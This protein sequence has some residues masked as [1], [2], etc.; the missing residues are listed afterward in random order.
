VTPFEVWTQNNVFEDPIEQVARY[1]DHVRI[2]HMEA[3][4]YN[5]EAEDRIGGDLV[6]YLSG[7]G[8]LTEEN[9]DEVASQIQNLDRISDYER[10][11]RIKA[12]HELGWLNKN[13]KSPLTRKDVGKIDDFLDLSARIQAGT[14]E[15]DET[16][17][18]PTEV[19]VKTGLVR[20]VLQRAETDQRTKLFNRGEINAAVVY[21][22]GKPRLLGGRIPEG[23]TI[24]D[25]IK[26]SS[27]YGVRPQHFFN[28]KFNNRIPEYSE[29][30]YTN[31]NT[32]LKYWEIQQRYIAE[33]EAIE[34]IKQDR[35]IGPMHQVSEN[36]HLSIMLDAL[37]ESKARS[38]YGFWDNVGTA[39]ADV[40]ES[41]GQLLAKIFG[42]QDEA[43][44]A[45]EEAEFLQETYAD[46]FS[47]TRDSLIADL[48]A[49]LD[50]S[51]DVLEDVADQLTLD[52]GKAK[53]GTGELHD[54]K[55]EGW[56]VYHENEDDQ[57]LNV[58][59]GT[60]KLPTV[61][62]ELKARPDLHANALD[63]A[64]VDSKTQEALEQLRQIEVEASFD[65]YNDIISKD[66]DLGDK[67]SQ[68][69]VTG[70][71][72]GISN[73]EILEQFTTDE[74]NWNK[75]S[76]SME[77]LGRSIWDE[78]V[79]GIV[80]GIAAMSGAEWGQQGLLK[81]ASEKAHQ[82]E[83]GRLFGDKFGL[84]QDALEMIAPVML[85]MGVTGL[86]AA[87]AAPTFG[88]TGAAAV[89]YV[90]AKTSATVA[91]RQII[92]AAFRGSLRVTGKESF[93]K[94]AK[95][96]FKKEIVGDLDQANAVIR[97][98]NSGL[99]KKIAMA[100][101]VF[102]PAANRSAGGTYGTVF[103]HIED[104][105]KSRHQNEDGTWEEG[106]SEERVK[107]EAHDAALGA[108]L[109]A[110]L[111]TG[112]L[113]SGMSM[114]GR[115][116]VEDALLRN[117]SFRQIKRITSAVLGRNV[118]NEAFKEVFKRS[119]KKAIRKHFI[120]APKSYLRNFA[121]E[122]YEE[123]LDE[124]LNSFIIDAATD[125]DTPFLERM[126]GV[127]HAALL[128][129]LMGAGSTFIGRTAKNVAPRM[130]LDQAAAA[131]F[132]KSL[133]EQYEKDVEAKGL[134]GQ[135]KR[136]GAP[137][138][139]KE[140]ERIIRRYK[141]A[142]ETDG[143][144]LTEE[145]EADE[146][147]EK[148]SP[149]D[150]KAEAD[151]IEEGMKNI[152]K[153]T[154]EEAVNTESAR[155][156]TK[157]SVDLETAS[158]SAATQ[159]LTESEGDTNGAGRVTSQ[160]SAKQVKID[161]KVAYTLNL[162]GVEKRVKLF[163][164][165]ERQLQ[166]TPEGAAADRLR[167]SIREA[168]ESGRVMSPEQG[169]AVK[170]TLLETF[171]RDIAALR[172]AEKKGP[173]KEAE[174][175]IESLVEGG[176]PHSLEVS[177][178]EDL[179][180]AVAET[181]NA[182]L[183][184]LTQTLAKKIRERFP[185]LRKTKPA[186]GA[187]V[188]SVYGGVASFVFVNSK[189]HG[190]FNNDP[191][192]MLTLLESN[193]AVPV[194]EEIVNADTTNPSFR[195]EQV[196]DQFF[197]SDI[198]VRE[199][200]GL[201]SAKTAFNKVGALEEDYSVF[202][203]LAQQVKAAKEAAKPFNG[204]VK[205]TDPFRPSRQITLAGL[206]KKASN[207]ELLRGAVASDE[208]LNLNK[209]F[210]EATAVALQLEIQ[211]A[212]YEYSAKSADSDTDSNIISILETKDRHGQFFQRQQFQRAKRAKRSF[213]SLLEPDTDLHTSEETYNP[214]ENGRDDTYVPPRLN[215]MRP[216]SQATLE[217][218][219]QDLHTGA[220]AAL[221]G[222]PE[223]LGAA[224]MLLNATVYQDAEG[225]ADKKTPEQVFDELVAYFVTGATSSNKSALQFQ[226]ELKAGAY[227]N[228]APLRKTLKIL[229]ISAPQVEASPDTD[230]SYAELVR[231]SLQGIMGEDVEVT[232]T[233]AKDF[234]KDVK[235][236]T[237]AFHSRAIVDGK[238]RKQNIKRN[239]KE[240]D[241]LG[242]ENGNMD[243]VISALEKISKGKNKMYALVAKIILSKKGLLSRINFVMD[244]STHAFAGEYTV[245]ATGTPQVAI[246]LAR[247]A[248]GGVEGV[249]LHELTHA[250][251]FGIL[252]T[253][254]KNRTAKENESIAALE[255]LFQQV[256]REANKGPQS[257][258]V[259]YAMSNL[260]EFLTHILVSP[261][262]QKYVKGIRVPDGSRNLL[263]RIL[264]R[265]GQ[266]MG[267]PS[268][269]YSEAV[270]KVLDIA[271]QT[272]PVTGGSIAESVAASV[273][274]SQ[275][276]RNALA[277]SI[278]G[279]G[280]A[281]LEEKLIESAREIYAWAAAF[282]PNEVNVVFDDSIDVIAEFNLDT[283][284][285][286]IN[287]V[288][289]A[290][291]LNKKLAE[292]GGTGIN[293]EHI[294]SQILN[295]EMA[296]VSSFATLTQAEINDMM[297]AMTN[298]E[299]LKVIEKYYP[300]DEQAEA[301]ERLNSPDPKVREAEKFI[302]VEESLRM[303]T[304]NV[305][306]GATTEENVDFLLENPPL[307]KT[308]QKYFKAQ[309]R[310][311]TYRVSGQ[312]PPYMRKSVNRMITEMRAME[313]GYRTSPNG[314]HFDTADPDATL[315]QLLKQLEMNKSVEG[316]DE[317]EDESEG[318]AVLT[319]SLQTRIG[320]DAGGVPSD[321]T[322]LGGLAEGKSVVTNAS[323]LP[324]SFIED[325]KAGRTVRVGKS[326][327]NITLGRLSRERLLKGGT[328]N[329]AFDE[330]YPLGVMPF[331]VAIR[332]KKYN[333]FNVRLSNAGVNLSDAQ[334]ETFLKGSAAS[335][336]LEE[337][338]TL[339]EVADNINR[340]AN[341]NRAAAKIGKTDLLL[342]NPE[343]ELLGKK[344]IVP[345]GTVVYAQ[346]AKTVVGGPSGDLVSAN[347]AIDI[348]D[349]DLSE[350]G[351]L[352]YN[353]AQGNYMYS[354]SKDDQ[355]ADVYNTDQ[356]FVSADEVMMVS[357]LKA[358][359]QGEKNPFKNFTVLARN[360][361]FAPLDPELESDRPAHER[362]RESV[363]KNQESPT[364]LQKLQ[365]RYGGDIEFSENVSAAQSKVD[366][367]MHRGVEH[368]DSGILGSKPHELAKLLDSKIAPKDRV[369]W[370]KNWRGQAKDWKDK[371]KEAAY[372]E[373]V[374]KTA[375][376]ILGVLERALYEYP[377]F[378][379][380]YEERV[381]MA[382]DIFEELDPDIKKPENSFVLKALLAVTSNGNKVKEQTEDSWRIYKQW[383][384]TGKFFNDEKPRGTRP[385]AING[386]LKLLDKWA[387]QHGWE[388]VEEFLSTTGTVAELRERLQVDFGYTKTQAEKLTTG[389]LIDETVPFALVFG[390]K[391]GSFHHNLNGNFDP[392]TMDLWFMRTFGR[393]IGA[394]LAKDTRAEFA[395]KKKRV[396]AALEAYIKTDP[397]GELFKQAGLGRKRKR[398]TDLVIGLAKFW[399]KPSH[400]QMFW[401]E[402]E[403]SWVEF[404][405]KMEKASPVTDELRK[406]TNALYKVLDNGVELIEA[407][408]S[409]GH[410]RFI[411]L[412]MMGAMDKL[413]SSTGVRMIPAEAQA[414]LWYYEKA[415]HKEFGSGQEE[416]P[417][418]AT[419]ANEVFRNE[420]GND[421]VSFRESTANQRRGR[422]S[423]DADGDRRGG[424]TPPKKL[425]SRYGGSVAGVTPTG[426]PERQT[427]EEVDDHYLDAV[428]AGDL[429]TAQIVIEE[430]AARLG[431]HLDEQGV[432]QVFA[433]GGL[434]K[435]REVFGP[436]AFWV[437]DFDQDVAAKYRDT[438][439]TY[440]GTPAI[441]VDKNEAKKA[442]KRTVEVIKKA[443]EAIRQLVAYN[444]LSQ[445]YANAEA[446]V[447][448]REDMRTTNRRA[449]PPKI[450]DSRAKDILTFNVGSAEGQTM[451]GAFGKRLIDAYNSGDY[452]YVLDNWD[453]DI[454]D[455]KVTTWVRDMVRLSKNE[456]QKAFGETSE[457][458]RRSALKTP[459]T[460]AFLKAISA[461]TVLGPMR[462]MTRV[463]IKT[464]PI[465]Y[466]E[467]KGGF[468]DSRF[469]QKTYEEEGYGT[470]W[471]EKAVGGSRGFD[472][473][474]AA[475]IVTGP[476]AII[477]S[478]EVVLRDE[479]G[480][481]IPPSK[482]FNLTKKSILQSRYGADSAESVQGLSEEYQFWNMPFEKFY[483]LSTS[484]AGKV[485][486]SVY[487]LGRIPDWVKEKVPRLANTDLKAFHFGL[488][489]L[490]VLGGVTKIAHV[491]DKAHFDKVIAY[492]EEVGW[493]GPLPQFAPATE[494]HHFNASTIKR[495]DFTAKQ[496]VEG[497]VTQGFVFMEEN[498]DAVENADKQLLDAA[499]LSRARLPLVEG[500]RTKHLGDVLR[501]A[502]FTYPPEDVARFLVRHATGRTFSAQDE[503]SL[504]ELV[505]ASL[506]TEAYQGETVPL[507]T[508]EDLKKSTFWKEKA[509]L[510]Y[511]N[512]TQE[513]RQAE[514]A[515]V[516]AKVGGGSLFQIEAEHRKHF[517]QSVFKII[518]SH[519]GEQVGKDYAYDKRK[520]ARRKAERLDMKY[521]A[522]R[523]RVKKIDPPKL[524]SRYGA[525]SDIPSVLDGDSVDYS[526]FV[527]LL[528]LPLMEIGTYKSPNLFWKV[529]RGESDPAILKFM[530]LRDAFI[531]EN[532][533][534]AEDYK[535]RFDRAVKAAKKRGIDIPPELI[536]QAGGS[537]RGSMLSDSQREAVDT[538][539]QNERKAASGIADKADRDLAL[540]IAKDN[541]DAE[542]LKYRKQNRQIEIAKRDRGLKDLMALDTDVWTIVLDLRK[543]TDEMSAKAKDLFGSTLIDAVFDTNL[544]IYF[545]RRFRMFEDND[546]A[547]TIKTDPDYALARTDAANYF[548]Q[549]YLEQEADHI[550]RNDLSI[551]RSDALDQAEQALH[552]K[553]TDAKTI[554]TN[555]MLDFID[556]YGNM[557]LDT[558]MD[559]YIGGDSVQH[560][561]MKGHT[562]LAKP[563]KEILS[564]FD[565]KKDI[566][567]P[568]QQL[569]G[570]Y[571]DEAGLDNALHTFINVGSIMSNQAFLQRVVAHGR[572]K[573]TRL[574]G[575]GGDTREPWM[576]TAEEFK[577][578]RE[579]AP[580][581]RKYA[582]WVQLRDEEHPDWNPASGMYMPKEAADNLTAMFS[583][584]KVKPRKMAAVVAAGVIRGLQIATGLSL[585]SKTLGAAGFYLRNAVGNALFFGP[586]QGHYGSIG[587]MFKEGGG[588][589][590]LTEGLKEDSLIRRAAFGSRAEMNAELRELAAM[591]VWGDEM[592]AQLLQDLLSGKKDYFSVQE[593]LTKLID[594]LGKQSPA[595]RVT[596]VVKKGW[597]AS[598]SGYN[599]T[600]GLLTRM[601]SAMDA[602]HK[603]S[604]YE[605]EL[606]VLVQAAESDP[607]GQFGR[608][609][610]PDGTPSPAMKMKAAEKVKMTSQTYSQAP[611]WVTGFT[612]GEIGIAI[613]PYLRFA[614]EVPRVMI[615]SY[616]LGFQE[617]R[618][619][620][621][622]IRNRGINRVAHSTFMLSFV[623]GVLPTMINRLW[624]GLSDDEEE[625]L[626]LSAPPY[627]RNNRLIYWKD[628]NG[629]YNSLDLT[630]LNPFSLVTNPTSSAVEHMVTGDWDE[631]VPSI[632]GGVAEGY[633]GEQ[634]L[635][636]AIMDVATNT[637]DRGQPIF[638]K[639]G[640][641]YG[642]QLWRGTLHIVDK[643]YGLRTPKKIAEAVSAMQGTYTGK[644]LMGRGP[645]GIMFQE[646]L[647][648][649]PYPIDL[650]ANLRTYLRDNAGRTRDAKSRLSRTYTKRTMSDEKVI[651]IY[652]DVA[653][654]VHNLNDELGT[655]VR[656]F[657]S[658]GLSWDE[659]ISEAKTKQVGEKR[660]KH[661]ALGFS[662]RIILSPR[663]KEIMMKESATRHRFM[664][665][666]NHIYK[667]PEFKRIDK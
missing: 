403:G 361:V 197:V 334:Y 452:N 287:G 58:H 257:G 124:L 147:L 473:P 659:I 249:L 394:Q 327:T 275:T 143:T 47:N 191:A 70:R 654:T 207:I 262:F 611:P 67:W 91:A 131:R 507:W 460:D 182:S 8:Y 365:T 9:R 439:G 449:A 173:S 130:F 88:A 552:A 541:R 514:R 371:G 518:D 22:D 491:E 77:G 628:K 640:D 178:L 226:L 304:Q 198:M 569:L 153:E 311:L 220:A 347:E 177:Q 437:Q 610:R 517:G 261:K 647:P 145:E 627:L 435:G 250:I 407:P 185:V 342:T 260:D 90:G 134:T 170:R 60:Y 168:V 17:V 316:R 31:K 277:S 599:A 28:I 563:L 32:L 149:E 56:Y 61:A 313:A 420:R 296:H 434:E 66:K 663:A 11:E 40:Y 222:D 497:E 84:G 494:D 533:K 187:K 38:K 373:D 132:E 368:I 564:S 459:K 137:T 37:T 189:G 74:A 557:K 637:D 348:S 390:A 150:V 609:L 258:L 442:N 539:Y 161:L 619:G 358:H 104:D 63:A 614:A 612:R 111:M 513:V 651:S 184:V 122:A 7:H 271:T 291:F 263:Q 625:A 500:A 326:H 203:E 469:Q 165:L 421:A 561:T 87:A 465:K 629:K 510:A 210:V 431:F 588:V 550:M 479:E 548:A 266:L 146:T 118:G 139:A 547:D 577:K 202:T 603:I 133:F 240:V 305:L 430:I 522:S 186:G 511:D 508:E 308:V 593:G 43:I 159:L 200:G 128:G 194:T 573:T 97:A 289:A 445:G 524:Q 425:Q 219:I 519:T 540:Q 457:L 542:T 80:H 283:Q 621:K 102:L 639:G 201:V 461:D 377:D 319:P 278:G 417:D 464:G 633:M 483:K 21:E 136:A 318:P 399:T 572:S 64:L 664:L 35:L 626:R 667:Q 51:R 354:A 447:L 310:K 560:I 119:I 534:T 562:H 402:S 227:T 392:I 81:T 587:A 98:Y 295:E 624:A 613:S 662:Q 556:S 126:Q 3:G 279:R 231:E 463:Y 438:A 312:V 245:D 238:S 241:A 559:A 446:T 413:E 660:V 657:H 108:G 247:R 317:E 2:A 315:R 229:G 532:K 554:G 288:R 528:D 545:T 251:T 490:R 487:S 558:S 384:A 52:N 585:A 607:S 107:A 158:S 221:E 140:A 581:D 276:R 652:E 106:W 213:V 138:T 584:D 429:A 598:A 615:N 325:A 196:G 527:E 294:L 523:Y 424:L 16:E 331:S 116:G 443:P 46:N 367:A 385:S 428:A 109:K 265:L 286:H 167:R 54:E 174:E 400:R 635:F 57:W 36:R 575:V 422:V 408:V 320:A 337:A 114:I 105:L 380:W 225:N 658:L 646:F 472:Q 335:Y 375:G 567:E 616:K 112:I 448:P 516:M 418:Y 499:N 370:K 601:A 268:R 589:L 215:P 190:V 214:E 123:G 650:S 529:F 396:D 306:R 411:R 14:Y 164:Q 665:L 643:A 29:S 458:I 13:D 129:G 183:A 68:A 270:A 15:Q 363:D 343:L 496:F 195:F 648:V 232:I 100:P 623:S 94:R 586:M 579:L 644:G 135:L 340:Q 156:K 42:G 193:V 59:Y 41:G 303:H 292:A 253:D 71:Q 580:D 1:M 125:E 49:K 551:S 76:E 606:R 419:A 237:Q 336:V 10:A 157:S 274:G 45:M 462:T 162:K 328:E 471:D 382:L 115:G 154:V 309:L 515:N 351:T 537:I 314:M 568:L 339:E 324:E 6:S 20:E 239:M 565:E 216:P 24:A 101:A 414:I 467:G 151:S 269:Q 55:P 480:N 391:L 44:R 600:L 5:E 470:I 30:L 96:L 553:G 653:D 478:A 254:P 404:S 597:D 302:L 634:I 416:A 217:G 208:S 39:S 259:D 199:S 476:S 255:A 83:M 34:L 284:S 362:L 160:H 485:Y 301:V 282:L 433:R 481:V 33:A 298:K 520:F 617:M 26:E 398:S 224:K 341:R 345:A 75:F 622:V 281:A 352:A 440:S 632:L 454:P 536:A 512:L 256:R 218:F 383:K 590:G 179:G 267:V 484:M 401:G 578:D 27:D 406:A 4:L 142:E 332:G 595:G 264:I 566:P 381:K 209:D 423:R 468:M 211:K 86:L 655:V 583:V 570:V 349:L 18:G 636:G 356:K 53:V 78:G 152:P 364:T 535:L 591:N 212:V 504:G 223:L 359:E 453:N 544:G 233:N 397:K 666:Q 12:A 576:I 73:R 155:K 205:V 272:D 596:G 85:D 95:D 531:R 246:N 338:M 630:Y 509:R 656:G 495:Y 357:D 618:S 376:K 393:T 330:S 192:G 82:R 72:Q 19:E 451:F 93:E 474:L 432:P 285:I 228:A 571:G 89:G 372:Y 415:V 501:G 649:K 645:L 117:M 355:G 661:S 180:V 631:V 641:D 360:A 526:N 366:E 172:E 243:S 307:I 395:A 620:N 444:L 273:V 50:Y 555:M 148:L 574:S 482:R 388:F 252:R 175:A 546:W 23:K 477:K 188:P 605:H 65:T 121:D 378:V 234:F 503:R 290:I 346:G 582:G 530:E 280:E 389:E 169:E 638:I 99:T 409:G 141:R 206:L 127:F 412:A 506:T 592:D 244:V 538:L 248:E 235:K 144:T 489:F 386:H 405:G 441:G 602:Y 120:D 486:D 450:G 48:G 488:D 543:L 455:Y 493:E 498:K 329:E 25:V 236:A 62:Q 181:D 176:F 387:D 608:L 379:S 410:R 521:G 322:G 436:I 549:Q 297:A 642:E 293:R 204:K 171:N 475:Q 103:K 369:D 374:E 69:V 300:A 426:F 230:P 299:A 110:G 350:W 604:L 502:A 492:L 525:A 323:P 113:T 242:L 163:R 427:A 333:A 166:E 321:H 466:T 456:V 594:K 505:P 353:P 79:L 344:Q 92:A